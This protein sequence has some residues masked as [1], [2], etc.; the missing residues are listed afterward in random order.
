MPLMVEVGSF[1]DRD[2]WMDL[3]E[4]DIEVLH[5]GLVVRH[6]LGRDPHSHIGPWWWQGEIPNVVIPLFLGW[7]TC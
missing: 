5:S 7:C 3:G 4:K 2:V 6:E 1:D